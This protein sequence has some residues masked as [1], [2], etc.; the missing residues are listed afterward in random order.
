MDKFISNMRRAMKRRGW[1][2]IADHR[3]ERYVEAYITAE[4]TE[5]QIR[6]FL[7]IYGFMGWRTHKTEANHV[8]FYWC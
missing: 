5:E 8:M 2:F 4:T 3:D 1:Q 7:P 6:D